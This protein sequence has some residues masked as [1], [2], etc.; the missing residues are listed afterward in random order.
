MLLR[1]RS[2]ARQGNRR[3][4]RVPVIAH[5]A[6]EAYLGRDWNDYDFLKKV[7]DAELR[8]ELNKMGHRFVTEPRNAQLVCTM[9]GSYEP[10]FLYFLDMGAGKT[11]LILDLIRFAK[12]T[13]SLRRALIVVP[14]LFHADSWADEFAK[15]GPD[16]TYTLL[17][18]SRKERSALLNER[19]DVCIINHAGLQVYMG[20]RGKK[21]E[22]GTIDEDAAL[23]FS[24]RFNFVCFDES[25]R[26]GNAQSMVW[27]LCAWIS[28]ACDFKYA[29]TGTPFGRDPTKLWPQFKLID[30]GETLGETLTFFRMVYM[31]ALKDYWAG[32]K[33]E[34]NEKMRDDLSR[35]MRHKSITFTE[36]ELTDL[37]PMVKMRKTVRLT[38]EGRDYYKRIVDKLIE[39]RGDY[40]SM[41]APFLRMRQVCSGFLSLKADDDSRVQIRFKENPKLDA[42]KQVIIDTLPHKMLVYYQYTPSGQWIV[43]M[44]KE[45]KVPYAWLWGGAKD[46]GA[47]YQRFLTDKKCAV[48]LLQNDLGAEVINPQYVCRYGI[49]YEN[50]IDPGKRAQMEKRLKRPGQQYV[51]YWTDLVVKGTIEE[52]IDQYI[53]EGRDLLKAILQG[54]ETLEVEDQ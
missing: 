17:V 35:I 32:V 25:H 30:E 38:E 33:W 7:P 16:L 24:Q 43:E 47:E 31:T 27:R 28:A 10:A 18:G 42:L 12:R 20:Q 23:E 4:Y 51:T 26:L 9:I 11:K 14:Y 36:K 19:T 48:F 37:P 15:H 41:K 5:S 2:L 3:H 45:M 54:A 50:T 21:D 52:K 34:F 46:P 29:L 8:A 39:T 6:L 13:G 53:K 1:R 22:K 40:R 44:L 49:S